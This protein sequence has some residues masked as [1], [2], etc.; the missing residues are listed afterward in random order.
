MKHMHMKRIYILF[1]AGVLAFQ[2]SPAFAQN[3]YEE[4]IKYWDEGPLTL[5]DFSRRTV[6]AANG[7]ISDLWYGW[8]TDSERNKAGNLIYRSPIVRTFMDR[9]NSW[10]I[11]S[12]FNQQQRLYLQTMFDMVEMIGRQYQKDLSTADDFYKVRNFYRRTLSSS[13]DSFEQESRSGRDS[14]VVAYYAAKIKEQLEEKPEA[15]VVNQTPKFKTDVAIGMYLGYSCNVLLSGLSDRNGP[16]NFFNFGFDIPFSQ[17]TILS[18]DMGLTTFSS[19]DYSGITK[20][21]YTWRN[22]QN[23]NATTFS[24]DLAYRVVDKPYFAIA[25]FLGAGVLGISQTLPRDMWKSDSQAE[26]SNLNGLR[27]EGGVGCDYKILRHYFP[28]EN[29]YDEL[30]LRLKLFGAYNNLPAVIG[31]TWSINF[32]VAI[33]WDGWITRL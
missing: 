4:S 17:R 2:A 22:G 14:S 1:F 33:G 6:P 9:L 28:M 5:A 29:S 7:A 8:E 19:M 20:D 31:P 26:S 12:E 27:V 25:P 18:W 13:I 11:I 15:P 21:G 23:T 3:K 32:G 10:V 16:L 24:F 30:Y